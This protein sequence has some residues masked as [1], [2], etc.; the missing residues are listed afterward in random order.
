M[1]NLESAKAQ[2]V[3][4]GHNDERFSWTTVRC[5]DVTWKNF[6]LRYRKLQKTLLITRALILSFLKQLKKNPLT[7]IEI[8]FMVLPW[9]N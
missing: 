3:V 9:V 5:V 6:G 8:G 2:E 7:A 1:K 4:K